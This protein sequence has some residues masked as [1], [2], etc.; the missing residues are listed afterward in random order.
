MDLFKVEAV[1]QAIHRSHLPA[2]LN[3]RVIVTTS[4]LRFDLAYQA[5]PVLHFSSCRSLR[6]VH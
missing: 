3:S 1:V 5:E 4:Q 2:S 6:H